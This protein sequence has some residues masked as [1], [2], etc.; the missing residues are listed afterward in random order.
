MTGSWRARRVTHRLPEPDALSRRAMPSLLHEGLI[1]LIREKPEFAAALLREILHVE[2]PQFTEA[3]LAEASL[4]EL[5]PA[6]FHADAVVLFVDGRRVFGC[7]TWCSSNPLSAT[8]LE[9]PSKLHPQA[10][11]LISSW[12]RGPFEKA[13]AAEKA[14]DVIAFLEARGLAVSDAQRQRIVET[15]DLETLSRWVRRA[16]TI[17]ATDALFE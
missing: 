9:R 2:V 14:T 16:A 17:T 3:R 12:Q 15:T 10:E 11:K 7:Y 4:N 13:R 8:L 5:I 1:A 6:E